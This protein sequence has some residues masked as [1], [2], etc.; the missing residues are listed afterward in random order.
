[1]QA[2]LKMKDLEAQTGVSREAIH[3]YLR[4]G[5]LPEPSRPKRNV[6]H[7]SDEHVVR[8]RA[9]KQLQQ[10]RAMSLDAIKR[11][12]SDF[13]YEAMSTGD[14][15]AQ[16]EL[17]V[18]AR[19]NGDLPT[20][21]QSVDAVLEKTGLSAALIDEL[22]AL[23]VIAIKRDNG[24]ALLDFRDV[25]VLELWAR[26]LSLGFDGK[27]GYDASYLKRYVDAIKPLVAFEVDNFLEVFG[28]EP[29]DETS[30]IAAE[31]I[32]IANEILG[33]LRTQA[34]MRELHA[35]VDDIRD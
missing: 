15:L 31:G 1:M 12:L 32:G 29:S 11:I 35:K 21:D 13:D 4:E 23:G 33:R 19:V 34:V 16:F 22:D 2:P 5:L 26:L 14:N 8:I 27:P 3:F 24:Q 20:R 10:D 25:G 18:Q 30:R 28:D 9:I 17:A 6:A 7:Y